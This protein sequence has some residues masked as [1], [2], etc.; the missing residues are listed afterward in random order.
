[1]HS[2]AASRFASTAGHH[3]FCD[4]AA[5]AASSAALADQNSRN[6]PVN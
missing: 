3:A 1:M 6:H 2:K 4:P 5:D